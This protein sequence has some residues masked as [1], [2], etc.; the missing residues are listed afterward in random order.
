MTTTT[1]VK[2]L[3]INTFELDMTSADI[4]DDMAIIGDGLDLDSVDMLEIVSQVEKKLGV[5]IRNEAIKKENFSSILNLT[6]FINA[7]S[8]STN[9]TTPVSELVSAI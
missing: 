3:L 9:K 5:K 7:C 8:E 6:K 2:E 4:S 1:Q